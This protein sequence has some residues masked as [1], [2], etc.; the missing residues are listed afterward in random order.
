MKT[1]ISAQHHSLSQARHPQTK[2]FVKQRTNG[3]NKT[4]PSSTLTTP[5]SYGLNRIL[6]PQARFQWIMP[7]LAAITP[8]YIEM[9][10]NGALAG[11]HVQRWE[12]FDLM[13]RTWPEL[14]QCVQE[15]I[16]GVL[17][18][19]LVYEA[20]HEED[21]KPTDNAIERMKVV[22]SALRQMQP[23]ADQD[24]NALEGTIKD[25]LDGWLR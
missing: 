12:L 22:S 8:Q 5:M 17:R 16:Y 15:L 3:H 14:A 19:K 11:N 23:R 10:L 7:N 4:D 24:A 20:F 1:R 18:K 13:L 2:R 9:I 21:E 25:I 6:R